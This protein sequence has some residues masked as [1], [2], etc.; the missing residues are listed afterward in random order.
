MKEYYDLFKL[1]HIKKAFKNKYTLLKEHYN[2]FGKLVKCTGLGWDPAVANVI[3]P[4][5]WWSDYV[6]FLLQNNPKAKRFCTKG[7]PEYEKLTMI[8]GDV[9]A[10]G[11]LQASTDHDFSSDD[12][13][14]D[15]IVPYT[16]CLPT[17]TASQSRIELRMMTILDGQ[18]LSYNTYMRAMKIL[19]EKGWRESFILISDGRRMDW[20][21]SVEDVIFD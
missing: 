6:Y 9:E 12:G 21:Q 5:Y 18:G 17:Q 3:V 2:E 13:E 7:C 10:T 19:K 1:K 4:T 16:Q 20:I 8:F 15:E 14:S 11:N